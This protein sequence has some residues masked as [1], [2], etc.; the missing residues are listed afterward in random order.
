MNNST[1][2]STR[3]LVR[4]RRTPISPRFQRLRSIKIRKFR[5]V[6]KPSQKSFDIGDACDDIY[7]SL[8]SALNKPVLFILTALVSCVVLT[9]QTSF[10]TSFIGK[11]ASQSDNT[12]SKWIIANSSKFLG[13]LIFLPAL[14]DLPKK[15]RPIASISTIFWTLLIP[16]SS[17][18]QYVVQSLALHT[19]F[20]VSRPNTRF[21]IILVVAVCYY[22]GWISPDIA[23]VINSSVK[24]SPTP[25]VN[26]SATT[27]N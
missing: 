21:L 10:A 20:K 23:K 15:I 24:K 18:Y 2:N 25:K 3:R 27:R 26:A 14:Y 5:P 7:T 16:E 4:V 22:F 8:T 19:Y 11:I 13:M 9:H 1:Q 6:V 12:V 17:I